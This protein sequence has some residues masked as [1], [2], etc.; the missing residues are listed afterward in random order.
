MSKARIPASIRHHNAMARHA[1]LLAL[2]RYF[3]DHAAGRDR[4]AAH[5]DY[6]VV[7]DYWYAVDGAVHAIKSKGAAQ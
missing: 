1:M 2:L 7:R 5:T 4:D 3:A 6:A